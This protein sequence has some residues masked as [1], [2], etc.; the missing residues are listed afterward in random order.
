MHTLGFT[1]CVGVIWILDTLEEIL[2]HFKETFPKVQDA[3]QNVLP[4]Y[5]D[6]SLTTI[7]DASLNLSARIAWIFP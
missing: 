4:F 6:I 1:I 3:F 2:Q 5:W 7:V